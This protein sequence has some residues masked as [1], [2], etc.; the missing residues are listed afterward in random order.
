MILFKNPILSLLGTEASTRPYVLQYYHVISLGGVFII[1]SM[2]P[3]NLIRCAGHA[4][5]AMIGTILG[6]VINII[7]DPIFLF[8]FHME[9]TGVAIATVF[10]NFVTDAYLIYVIKHKCPELSVSLKDAHCDT[11]HINVSSL[12]VSQLLL[13]ISCSLLQSL[14]LIN[15][16]V[17]MDQMRLPAWE[18]H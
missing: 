16:Y 11:R 6:C 7:L 3:T 10:S 4:Q 12:L 5:D 17:P 13:Q 2:I 9:A 14:L 15:I 8:V 1:L 18:S